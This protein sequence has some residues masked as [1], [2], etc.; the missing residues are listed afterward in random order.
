[1]ESL[2]KRGDAVDVAV[3]DGRHG[4]HEEVDAL[5]VRERV[6]V[7]KA[8]GIARVLQLQF[9]DGAKEVWREREDGNNDKESPKRENRQSA[10]SLLVMI[11]Q[12]HPI[13]R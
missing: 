11:S 1:M 5:P 6:A 8:G 3:A 9:S 12:K 2:A 7:V 10:S 13:R 4:H